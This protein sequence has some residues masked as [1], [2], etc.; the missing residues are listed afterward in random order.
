MPT[1]GNGE[2]SGQK[3]VGVGSHIPVPVPVEGGGREGIW[4]PNAHDAHAMTHPTRDAW[5]NGEHSKQRPVGIGGHVLV[6]DEDGVERGSGTLRMCTTPAP[7]G[8]PVMTGN[9]AGNGSVHA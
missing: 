4:D 1:Q 3:P 5:G 8:A 6:L 7:R 2:R 9:A